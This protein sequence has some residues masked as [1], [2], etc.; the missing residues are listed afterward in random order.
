MLFTLGLVRILTPSPINALADEVT[1][2]ESNKRLQRATKNSSHA[3]PGG[4]NFW[5][6]APREDRPLAMR[7]VWA[8]A[9]MQCP[10]LTRGADNVAERA[11]S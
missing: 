6:K 8:P 4:C 9:M 1:K 7:Q 2:T 11:L 5:H 3:C 10:L